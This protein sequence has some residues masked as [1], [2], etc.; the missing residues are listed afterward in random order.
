M[1]ALDHG[2]PVERVLARVS[3][4]GVSYGCPD[5]ATVGRLIRRN[6]EQ[7]ARINDNGGHAPRTRALAADNDALALRAWWLAIAGPDSPDGV[8]PL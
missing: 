1:G 8:E 3:G 7:I 6:L 4:V 5:V 2:D